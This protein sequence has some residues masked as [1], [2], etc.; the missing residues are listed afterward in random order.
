MIHHINEP[1][2][3]NLREDYM[4]SE[5]NNTVE[6]TTPTELTTEWKE[7]LSDYQEYVQSRVGLIYDF[8][9]WYNISTGGKVVPT[10]ISLAARDT[11]RDTWYESVTAFLTT[12]K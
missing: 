8:E 12:A 2:N 1:S 10:E 7:I 5:S 6:P 3:I 4:K 9:D 11:I